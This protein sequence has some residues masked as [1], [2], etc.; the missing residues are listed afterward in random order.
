MLAHPELALFTCEDCREWLIDLK[1]GTP[2]QRGGEPQ[3]RRPGAPTPCRTC[4]R[5]SPERAAAI[6]LGRR[7]F[8]TIHFY[9][10]VRATAGAC[11]TERER[12]DPLLLRN[13]A[14]VDGVFRRHESSQAAGDLAGMLIAIQ[15]A[16][17]AGAGAP[18]R[19][20]RGRR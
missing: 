4:P 15:R 20:S 9:L 13:L 10:Q 14:I 5:E 11:L 12:M 18:G 16:A 3:R 1:T 8:A 17:S 2:I 7:E 6:A 19:T